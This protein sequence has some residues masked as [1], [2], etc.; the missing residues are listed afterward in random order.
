VNVPIVA[1]REAKSAAFDLPANSTARGTVRV[2]FWSDVRDVYANANLSVYSAQR[3]NARCAFCVEELRP[4]SRGG[5]LA[6]QRRVEH[7]DGAWFD[8]LERV[9]DVVQRDLRPSVSVTG[10]EPS[11]D[12]RL[13]RVL[14][15][16]EACR[17]R[18]RTVTTNG[19][20]LL[21][22]REGRRVIDWIAATGVAHLNVSRAHP[23]QDVNARL[24]AYADGPTQD[25]MRAVVA[26]ARA[27]GTRV[28]LSC[29]LVEGAIDGV[30][31][32][33]RYLDF[34]RSLGV[35][36]V[37]FR[38]LML[39]DPRTTQRNHVVRFS[40][41]KRVALDSLL[42]RLGDDPRFDFVRQIV[43]Y[44]YYVE[45]W[46]SDGVDVVF[47]EAD[48]ARLEDEKRAAPRLVHELVFHPDGNLASTWQ[49]W[50]GVLGPR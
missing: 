18:K 9:L 45:V 10:G 30:D 36:N 28:R 2:D 26:A 48:L 50:D 8:R 11:K 25:A 29:V 24:V 13:P 3:C 21:D 27:G 14:R 19:S 46:R 16:L 32:I 47:E 41:R 33:V 44:Y 31:G 42:G 15:T 22:V 37:I 34:A 5:E 1:W 49:P 35:D 43:G 12:P 40:D 7:D 4:A 38:R 23:D 20:G 17:T 39:T 6:L